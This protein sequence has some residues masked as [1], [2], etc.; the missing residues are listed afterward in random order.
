[1]SRLVAIST[2][3]ACLL[4]VLPACAEV[5]A[6]LTIGFD[7]SYDQ[8]GF[9]DDPLR[10][11]LIELAAGQINRFID[12]LDEIAPSGADQWTYY[13]RRPDDPTDVLVDDDV[14]P[15]DT[16]KVY[17]GGEPLSSRYLALTYPASIWM[18]SGSQQW[19]DTVNYRGQTGAADHPPSDYS[20]HAASVSFNSSR[21]WHFGHTTEGLSEDNTDF[22]TVAMHELFHVLGLGPAGSWQAGI[23]DGCF[24]GAHATAT[25][26]SNN[27]ELELD[28]S[29]GHWR[30][31]T[32]G[33][34]G[35]Q[36]Q[37]ALLS[38]YIVRNERRWPTTLDRAALLDIGWREA[39][40]G[41][42]DLDRD[43]DPLDIQGILAANKFAIGASNA[44][45]AE[46]DFDGNQQVDGLDI[47][48]I[49]ATALFGTG[50]YAAMTPPHGS[51]ATVEL[52]LNRATGGL[53]IH[54][55]GVPLSGYLIASTEGIFTGRPAHNLGQFTEDGDFRISGGWGFTLWGAHPLGDV[56]GPQG[57]AVDPF[58]D[59]TFTYTLE[60]TPGVFVGTIVA[61]PE[62]STIA[63]L[64]G[65]LLVVLLWAARKRRVRR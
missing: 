44:V 51:N 61:V 23:S 27:P 59:L 34:V 22:L 32:Q 58:D 8:H 37:L 28:S 60:G 53:T 48:M 20:P 54:S 10:R 40:P 64:A 3:L 15:A 9:F 19:R 30:I 57:K 42:V 43:V 65:G 12:D 47:Q 45:W 41:D 55:H 1:M 26:S 33:W 16:V 31:D 46:G 13:L 24:T 21:D 50:P 17:V 52:L 35:D 49:L 4:A 6:A 56:I 39:A 18:I 36:P 38:P 11:E 7:Y 25:G 14:I 29:G 5:Q 2:R 62:P 63:G